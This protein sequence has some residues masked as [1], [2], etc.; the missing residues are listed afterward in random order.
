MLNGIENSCNIYSFLSEI[1][2]PFNAFKAFERAFKCQWSTV[3]VLRWNRGA[4]LTG[5]NRFPLGTET[6]QFNLS[7]PHQPLHC[8]PVP[9]LNWMVHRLLNYFYIPVFHGRLKAHYWSDWDHRNLLHVWPFKAFLRDGSQVRIYWNQ[10]LSEGWML[11]HCAMLRVKHS[12]YEKR[13]KRVR[14]PRLLL[15]MGRI[16]KHPKCHCVL[17]SQIKETL[18]LRAGGSAG[19]LWFI[20]VQI[21][22]VSLFPKGSHQKV[23]PTLWAI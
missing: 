19:V 20:M 5:T 12:L 11:A 13:G 22:R 16:I 10:F 3:A 8:H 7:A 1:L 2:T 17:S 18:K 15:E 6:P 23:H 9:L 4:W 21:Q 14:A